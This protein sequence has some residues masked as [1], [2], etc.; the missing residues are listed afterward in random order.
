MRLLLNAEP[1]GFGP[2]AAI[3]S[4]HPHLKKHFNDISYIGKHHTLD[5]QRHLDYHDIHDISDIDR[6][7]NEDQIISIL[8]DYDVFLSAM[9]HKMISL[10]QKAGL[11]TIY[12]DALAWY[13]DK[14]PDHVKKADLYIAQDFYGVKE[15]IE[16]EFK[17]RHNTAIISPIIQETEK[18][19]DEAKD[20]K[21]DL[22]LINLGGLQNP[23]WPIDDIV[24]YARLLVQ[25]LK[26]SL[27]H[28]GID[29]S[30]IVIAGSVAV[31]SRLEYLGVKTYERAAMQQILKQT[32]LSI[33]TPGL[34]NIYD[35]ACHDIPTLWLPPANDSQGQQLRLLQEHNTSDAYIE[36]HDFMAIDPIVYKGNQQDVL[37]EISD[38]SQMMSSDDHIK[39]RFNVQILEGLQ[40]I[41]NKNHSKTTKLV[42]E[43]GANGDHDVARL[44]QQKTKEWGFCHV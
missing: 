13:W 1:F 21:R 30:K 22:I 42:R 37:R 10:A 18:N 44:L 3:A 8:S 40:I 6:Q 24:T 38:I 32:K 19:K 9:D 39:R 31:A 35:A 12:Y 11:K 4:F 7:Q 28:M 5:L 36:W 43:F 26:T 29:E 20:K 2:T 33:M 15:R 23:Y 34:G 16:T 14:I 25:S 17:T 27:S 41:K